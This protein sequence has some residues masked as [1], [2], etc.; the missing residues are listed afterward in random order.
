M[1]SS[2][3]EVLMFL[4]LLLFDPICVTV[5]PSEFRSSIRSGSRPSF[6]LF[7]WMCLR[8]R[9]NRLMFSLILHSSHWLSLERLTRS[10]LQRWCGIGLVWRCSWWYGLRWMERVICWML[11]WK[12]V[13]CISIGRVEWVSE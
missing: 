4:L 12:V 11:F 5:N 1:D 2:L 7:F 3:V 10:W 6:D 13:G 8:S 9:F